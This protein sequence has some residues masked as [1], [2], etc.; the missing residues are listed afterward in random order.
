MAPLTRA[1]PSRLLLLLA[2][3]ALLLLGQAPTASA[4]KSHVI[5]TG[6]D[7]ITYFVTN[8]APITAAEF[9]GLAAAQAFYGLPWYILTS[10]VQAVSTQL[11]VYQWGE[12]PALQGRTAAPFFVYDQPTYDGIT[13]AEIVC[14]VAW[15][16][17]STHDAAHFNVGWDN[18][19]VV[20]WAMANKV[21]SQLQPY[22]YTAHAAGDFTVPAAGGLLREAGTIS[23]ALGVDTSSL[24]VQIL[25]ETDF[26]GTVTVGAG[27]AFT[28][29]RPDPSFTGTVS[30]AFLVT[31]GNPGAPAVYGSAQI[32]E[33]FLPQS[34][35]LVGLL[36]SDC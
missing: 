31:D 29:Q 3:A 10:I 13:Y 14:L 12:Q 9:K 15:N 32:G 20:A 1:A 33:L 5:V 26:Q 25:T 11:G 16:A 6:N 2:A 22:S 30:F 18:P 28:Y 21:V 7:G 34:R 36:V 17:G 27:G 24:A 19:D 4:A 8:T 23:G 35:L